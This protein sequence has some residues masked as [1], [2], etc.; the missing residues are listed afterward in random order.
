ML[1]AAAL[2]WAAPPAHA[3]PSF[4]RM[5]SV[6]TTVSPLIA[7]ADIDRDGRQDVVVASNY[8]ATV[9]VLLSRTGEP[10]VLGPFAVA[11][12]PGYPVV[13][14]LDGDERLDVATAHDGSVSVLYAT[15]GG[16]FA[17]T[18]YPG[19][20]NALRLTAADLTRDGRV[21]LAVTSPTANTV[22]ILAGTA[23]GFAAPVAY[24]TGLEPRAV[25]A[26]DVDAD[27]RRIS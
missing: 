15:A 16:S 12:R 22:S 23:G 21:D 2:L 4:S 7:L 19:P 18:D 26:G 8:E 17:R 10:E 25:V 9:T 27:G 6:R 24:A 11:T 14:D 3:E 20:A 5:E 13:A 1:V